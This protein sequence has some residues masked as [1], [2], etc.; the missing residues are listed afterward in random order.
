MVQRLEQVRAASTHDLAAHE[1]ADQLVENEHGGRAATE[2]AGRSTTNPTEDRHLEACKAYPLA[3]YHWVTVIIYAGQAA[4]RAGF[5]G[6]RQTEKRETRE[7]DN[8]TPLNKSESA[9]KGLPRDGGPPPPRRHCL[10]CHWP[11]GRRARR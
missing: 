6:D 3:G 5:G 2:P 8:G 9:R 10:Q 4:D 7:A 1:A 11:P